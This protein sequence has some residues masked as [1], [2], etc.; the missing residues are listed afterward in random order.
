ML[1]VGEAVDDSL[2]EGP[3]AGSWCSKVVLI[4]EASPKSKRR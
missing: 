4:G 3:P 1:C 2:A